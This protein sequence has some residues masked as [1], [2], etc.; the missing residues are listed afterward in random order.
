MKSGATET[1]TGN[2]GQRWLDQWR[3]AQGEPMR[4]LVDLI[5]GAL[6][7]FE[8]RD[9]EEDRPGARKRGRKRGDAGRFEAMVAVIIVELAYAVL[10][11]PAS[12]R[13]AVT[14]GHGGGP[15]AGR[16]RYDNPAFGEGL[17]P[18]LARLEGVD[19]LTMQRGAR[20]VS[21]TTIAPSKWFASMVEGFGARLADF[22]RHDAEE[23]IILNRNARDHSPHKRGVACKQ[24]DAGVRHERID[25][26][27]TKETRRFRE[28]VRSVN[29][30]LA[31]ANIAFLD[32]GAGR[33]NAGERRLRRY[34]SL[35]PGQTRPRFDQ[36]GR[37][38]GAF[39]SNLDRDRRRASLRIDGEPIVEVDANALFTRL[40][41]AR[42]GLPLA[43]ADPYDA[44]ASKLTAAG[45]ECQRASIKRA[46]NAMFFGLQGARWPL[47][48][49][50]DMPPGLTVAKMR[51]AVLACLPELAAF[52]DN[53][54]DTT[55]TPPP[56]FGF[57][58]TESQIALAVMRR[59]IEQGVVG[60]PLHD[61]ILCARS[62]AETVRAALKEAAL[63]VAG[64][65]IPI[66]I[67]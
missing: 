38:F 30:F 41:Y 13:I 63:E 39:W 66:G 40:A 43:D 36:G 6:A 25:Y 56:G 20:G 60:L 3:V 24:S 51:A 59:L 33:V 27:D 49:E 17:G 64:V 37:L 21:A 12:G 67:K 65:P 31:E 54:A 26:Q 29:A 1:S 62:K 58:F 46:V 57:M 16:G 28:E 23:L 45:F 44:V 2:Q 15:S 14:L 19:V 50:A 5:Q 52:F 9:R 7:S 34:F 4:A 18:L 22:G 11:P 32:D 55:A 61:G 8:L 42:L 53:A 35:L 47:D 10:N 48:V